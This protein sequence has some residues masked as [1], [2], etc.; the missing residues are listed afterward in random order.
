M[1]NQDILAKAQKKVKAKKGFY[2]HLAVYLAM[3]M[4]FGIL[5]SGAAH[6]SQTA[7]VAL[8]PWG[9]GLF[10]HYVGVFGIPFLN[11][12]G[13]D[14][15]KRQLEKEVELLKEKYQMKENMLLS[16]PEE[17][18]MNINQHDYQQMKKMRENYRER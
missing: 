1:N 7:L 14:W 15:E 5:G 6:L 12:L 11:V 18:M 13:D 8:V 4:F 3:G 9:V 2:W 17:D 16:E 10:L